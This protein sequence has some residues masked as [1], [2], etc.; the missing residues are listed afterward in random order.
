[1]RDQNYLIKI[2]QTEADWS[3]LEQT[4]INWSKLEQTVANWSK[5]EQTGE[6]WRKLMVK[7]GPKCVIEK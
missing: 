6:N 1:M 7:N 5:S 2:D 4:G 3:K